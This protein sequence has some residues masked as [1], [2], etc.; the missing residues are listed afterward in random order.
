MLAHKFPR[1]TQKTFLNKSQD[2][3]V[4]IMP[5][6]EKEKMLVE[7]ISDVGYLHPI[8]L[9]QVEDLLLTIEQQRMPFIVYETYRTPQRQAELIRA[10]LSKN[11]NAFENSHVHGLAIDFLIDTRMVNN[12]SKKQL[13]DLSSGNIKQKKKK[14][15][16]IY[17]IGVNVVATEDSEPRTL[18]ENKTILNFWLDLGELVER[19]YPDLAWGG[20]L[21]KDKEQLI[22]ADPPHIELRGA[23]QLIQKKQTLKT[24]KSQGNPGLERCI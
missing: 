11:E 7:R 8:F 16:A 18:I 17:N 23:R 1:L 5:H 19:Q 14:E 13:S 6:F 3:K 15:K 2:Y 20:T 4:D 12:S 9:R 21:K 24:L 22:G 10:G